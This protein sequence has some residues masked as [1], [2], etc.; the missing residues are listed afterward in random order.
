[1]S[2]TA[3]VDDVEGKWKDLAENLGGQA[4]VDDVEGK[5]KDFAES[6]NNELAEDVAAS[7]CDARVVMRAKTVVAPLDRVRI[8][9]QTSHAQSSHHSDHWDGWLRAVREI[10]RSQGLTGLY[11]GHLATL[12]RNSPYSGL[13]FLAYEKYHAALIGSDPERETPWRRL[14]SG[15]L[16][17][18]TSTPVTYPL[19]LIRIPS[20]MRLE[21]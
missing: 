8:L 7:N 9:F 3:R 14:L 15:G 20:L 2:G 13:N 11:K 1:M 6:V 10:Y 12:A 16:A 18:A 4:C 5:W 17:G 21:K 19:E